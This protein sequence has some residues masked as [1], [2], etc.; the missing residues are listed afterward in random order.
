MRR[1]AEPVESE[2]SR[3]VM[4]KS[5]LNTDD[6]R[7]HSGV[8]SCALRPSP[9]LEYAGNL[10]DIWMNII[11]QADQKILFDLI[12]VNKAWFQEGIGRHWHNPPASA[13]RFNLT[14]R[15]GFKGPDRIEYYA[16][17]IRH[18]QYTPKTDTGNQS[19]GYV[20]MRKSDAIPDLPGLRSVEFLSLSLASRSDEQL[21]RIFRPSLRHVVFDDFAVSGHYAERT[22]RQNGAHWFDF[23]IDN[24]PLLESISLGE[25]LR[26]SLDQFHDCVCRMIRLRSIS[27]ERGNEHLIIPHLGPILKSVK[28]GPD[29]MME[30]DAWNRLSQMRAL[31]YL[32]IVVGDGMVTSE[33]LLQLEGLN[34]LKHLHIWPANGPETTRCEVTATGLALFLMTLPKLRDFRLWL[35]FDFFRHEQLVKARYGMPGG[36]PKFDDT[37]SRDDYL[38][39]LARFAEFES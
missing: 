25:G 32:D 24:C 36:Y 18:L 11:A 8:R 23:M 15:R 17:L 37:G 14:P 13:L 9:L 6:R 26:I 28:I 34:Q 5:P 2:L 35:E 38:E 39:Y 21:Q 1:S 12:R 33:K 19:R 10:P 7:P 4:S 16:G 30:T 22:R 31:V 3:E 29:W 20:R 27:L